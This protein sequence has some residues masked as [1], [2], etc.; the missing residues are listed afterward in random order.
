MALYVIGDTH[1]SEGC[2]KPMDIFGG[3]WTGYRD[4]LVESLSVLQ[5]EDVLVL[6]GDFSWGMSLQEALP[7]FRLL[8]S[9][10][11]KNLGDL[12]NFRTGKHRRIMEK[13]V[14]FL[15]ALIYSTL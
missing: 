13:T 5:P 8:D 9:F 1:F 4:K 14:D 3:A 15:R 12:G 11:G 6:A 10:P 2:N 7:D